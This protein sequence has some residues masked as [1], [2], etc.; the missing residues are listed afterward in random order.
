[1][2]HIDFKDGTSRWFT[3]EQFKTEMPDLYAYLRAPRPFKE[4]GEKI[5]KLRQKADM[6]VRELAKSSGIGLGDLSAIEAGRVE[7]TQEQM[8]AI[9]YA[10]Q[11]GQP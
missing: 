4:S 9:G 1:M 11:M 10:L 6:T 2:I 3:E 5:K 7:P 8:V